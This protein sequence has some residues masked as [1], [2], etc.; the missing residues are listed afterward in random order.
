M[1]A[2]IDII[3]YLATSLHFITCNGV[4]WTGGVVSVEEGSKEQTENLQ[5]ALGAGATTVVVGGIMCSL[6]EDNVI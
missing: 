1:D 4:K 6:R 5:W 3:G 2:K